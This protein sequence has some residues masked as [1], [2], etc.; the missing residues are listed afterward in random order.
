MSSRECLPNHFRTAIGVISPLHE[1]WPGERLRVESWRLAEPV[2]SV[3]DPPAHINDRNSCPERPPQRQDEICHQPEYGEAEPED[4]SLHENIL[5][6][7]FLSRGKRIKRGDEA[8]A[9]VAH[10]QRSSR[11]CSS[12]RDWR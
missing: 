11:I 4:L 10:S 3:G 6:P 8:F 12:P 1:R 5:A 7:A 2:T 9:Q